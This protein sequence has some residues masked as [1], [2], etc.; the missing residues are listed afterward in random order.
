[1]VE[2]WAHQTLR[3]RY[4][5]DQVTAAAAERRHQAGAS[6]DVAAGGG[7][8]VLLLAHFAP[9]EEKQRQRCAKQ[10]GFATSAIGRIGTAPLPPSP[11]PHVPVRAV[12]GIALVSV[13]A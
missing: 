12:S 2:R 9:P 10:S 13:A 5:G 6:P 8:L 4:A 11:R 3:A 7:A 1:M